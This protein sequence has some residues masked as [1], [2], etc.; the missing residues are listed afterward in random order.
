MKDAGYEVVI[1]W[2]DEDDTYVAKLPE[3]PGCTAHGDT[4]EEAT[5]MVEE[6]IAGVIKA[7]CETGHCLPRPRRR[8]ALV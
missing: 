2:S 3:P 7:A 8:L 6:A 1:Y 4:R 5:R